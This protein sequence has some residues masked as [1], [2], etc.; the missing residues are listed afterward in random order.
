MLPHM[1]PPTFSREL[2]DS[3]RPISVTVQFDPIHKDQVVARLLKVLPQGHPVIKIENCA[4]NR[5]GI[6]FS[7]P[8]YSS[9]LLQS[10]YV[11]S[12]SFLD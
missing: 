1:R 9:E 10:L 12:E 11:L 7:K 4:E 6:T 8:G 2:D 3:D 5:C